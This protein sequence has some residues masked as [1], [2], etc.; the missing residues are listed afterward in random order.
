V[1]AFL[2]AVLDQVGNTESFLAKISLENVLKRNED[3]TM[4]SINPFYY[5][6]EKRR[7]DKR[8]YAVKLFRDFLVGQRD[9]YQQRAKFAAYFSEVKYWNRR[10][11]AIQNYI[12][13]CDN[14]MNNPELWR[15]A[16]KF[17]HNFTN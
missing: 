12:D 1:I 17:Y 2:K 16:M 10:S 7:N 13:I 14:E 8:Q 9:K 11:M 6:A 4:F 3:K 15:V 5:W